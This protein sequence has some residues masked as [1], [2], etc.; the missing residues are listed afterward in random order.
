[1]SVPDVNELVDS[2]MTLARAR[3]GRLVAVTLMAPPTWAMDAVERRVC[4][5][6]ESHGEPKVEVRARSG[7]GPI[8]LI[9]AEFRR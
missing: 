4:A 3:P 9:T 2:V 1:M 8:R 7:G 6:L 5:E